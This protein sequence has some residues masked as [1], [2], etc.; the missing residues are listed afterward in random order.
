MDEQAVTGVI[1]IGDLLVLMI[2]FERIA[3]QIAGIDSLEEASAPTGPVCRSDA[4]VLLQNPVIS[5]SGHRY[6]ANKKAL[7]KTGTPVTVIFK[8]AK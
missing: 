6:K 5:K 1:Q 4:T 2:D 7:P 3:F 8:A